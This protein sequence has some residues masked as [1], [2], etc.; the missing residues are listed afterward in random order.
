MFT[1][2]PPNHQSLSSLRP[3]HNISYNIP[4]QSYKTNKMVST[5]I[6]FTKA[7][8]QAPVYIAGAFSEWSPVEMTC[9]KLE[10]GE[11]KFSHAAELQPGKYQYKFRLGP[12]DWW[13]LDE[14]TSTG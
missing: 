3:L 14:S 6:T 13:V 4:I 10:N 7:D 2:R 1:Y 5:I 9:E 8:V 12:G 11:N